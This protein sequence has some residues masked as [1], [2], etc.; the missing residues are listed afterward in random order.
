MRRKI[1][2][3]FFIAVLLL[4]A[5]LSATFLYY[6]Y[7]PSKLKSF[8]ETSIARST[9]SS[10]TIDRLSYSI[11]PLK[12][13]ME[14]ISLKPLEHR[15]GFDLE[16]PDLMADIT[17]EGPFGYKSL[18][19]TALKINGFSLDLTRGM[20]LP[21]MTPRVE[22]ASYIYRTLKAFIAFFFFRD[23]KFKA[24][25]LANGHIAARSG[26]KTIQVRRIHAKLNPD[27]A[28]SIKCGI[29]MHCPTQKAD[30]LAPQVHITTENAI[31]LV[32]P[33]VKCLLRVKNA[34][35]Q[36]PNVIAKDMELNAALIYGH[37]NKKITFKSMALHL[38]RVNLKELSGKSPLLNIRLD[39]QGTFYLKDKHI[40]FQDF[41]LKVG[42]IIELKGKLNA[43]LEPKTSI[44]LELFESHL[45]PQKIL[46]LLPEKTT[47]Q[48]VPFHLSGP[49]IVHGGVRGIKKLQGWRWHCILKGKLNQNF[50]TY[51]SEK[52]RLNGPINGFILAEGEFPD[53]KI[54]AELKGDKTFLSIKG[55]KLKPFKTNLALAGIYPIFEIEDLTAHMP[56]ARVRVGKRDILIDDIQLHIRQGSLN[57]EKKSIVLPY[58]RLDSSLLKNIALNIELDEKQ[59]VVHLQGKDIYLMKSASVLNFLP[60]GWKMNCLDSLKIKAILRKNMPLHFDSELGLT[61]LGLENQDG[62][63]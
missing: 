28:I 8:L 49:I 2:L 48:L 39:T 52:I 53:L 36:V 55:V 27:H 31:S 5:S 30:F 26:D 32:E 3:G 20:S 29:Q 6:Y 35:F 1:F 51:S 12:I 15:H 4:L 22:N 10:L 54:S 57:G 58:I 33:E 46:H 7:H 9:K 61:A 19:F 47:K 34:T 11:N 37:H 16:I 43:G 14:G 17:L 50:Y 21:D 23:I 24:A 60:S 63:C 62:T 59:A 38:E 56:Q 41:N 42:D 13:R 45:L 18:I 25:E 40:D 44:N